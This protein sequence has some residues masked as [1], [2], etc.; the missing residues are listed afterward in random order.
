M[1]A[2]KADIARVYPQLG[3]VEIEHIWTG[4]LGNSLHRMPQIGEISP[5]FWLASGF[6][7]HGINTT[8]MAG[9]I[10]AKAITEGDDTWR[11]FVPFEL[12]WAGGA[13][14][15]AAAQVHY[16][17]Y[18][19]N[20]RSKA[21]QARKREEEYRRG[22]ARETAQHASD[23]QQPTEAAASERAR[24]ETTDVRAS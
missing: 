11:R 16:W 21:R 10:I 14:G 4:V 12:V 13:I 19:F 23:E 18:G 5:R 3:P 17:W 1:R 9:N 15:R 6:G 22:E 7:G 8:A 24:R 2:L 20:E